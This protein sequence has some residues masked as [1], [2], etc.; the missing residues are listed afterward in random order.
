MAAK[1]KTKAKR[2]SAVKRGVGRPKAKTT[3][4]RTGRSAA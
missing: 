2:A 4:K 3:T 1:T